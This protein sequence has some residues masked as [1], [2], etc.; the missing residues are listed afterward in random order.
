MSD[1]TQAIAQEI[2]GMPVLSGSEW[3]VYSLVGEVADDRVAITGYR[4]TGSGPAV[5]TPIPP[6]YDLLTELRDSARG[7]DGAT[8]DVVILKLR[9]ATGELAME[10]LSGDAADAWRVTPA[11]ID[12]LPEA[13]RLRPEDFPTAS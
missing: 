7:P 8:W 1:L 6:I 2:L 9:R 11:N 4:Y 10:V 12:R 3:D 5:P 13:L